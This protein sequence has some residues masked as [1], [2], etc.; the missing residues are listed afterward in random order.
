MHRD[1]WEAGHRVFGLYHFR[2]DKC[3]CG[4]SDC[5]AAGKHPVS[6]GWQHTPQWD[7]E[8]IEAMEMAG[9]F[10]TGFGVL[11]RGL[12]VVDVD[13][14]N[15]GVD[16]YERLRNDF[17]VV[18]K[19]GLIVATG[20]GG[21][22]RHVYF[23][24]PLDLALVQ[25]HA[26]YP[27]IDFKSSGFVVGPGSL[28]VSGARYT[29]EYGSPDDIDNAPVELIDLL[30]KPDRHRSEVG[31]QVVDV[32]HADLAEM[33]AHVEA[34]ADHETWVRCGMAVHHAS[35]GTGFEIW[36]QWSARG[37]KYPGTDVLA[38]RWHSFGKASNPVTLGTLT[39]YAEQGGWRASVT[40]DTV[41]AAPPIALDTEVNLKRPPGLVGKIAEWIEDQCR[42]PREHLAVAGA[43]MAVG[44]IV[45]LRYTDDI[46]KVT[47]NLFTF[48]VAAS[49]TGKE[50]VQQAIIECHV[51]AGVDKA[52]HGAIK[53]EQEIV[54]NLV[55]HQAS[56]YVV[57]EIGIFLKKVKNA[58]TKGGAAYLDGIIGQL[59]SAYSKA[60]GRMLLTGD[61][62]EEVRKQ[63]RQELA[64]LEKQAEE[65][66]QVEAQIASV[67]QQMQR[68]SQGLEKPFL[69]L[70]G[71]TTPETFD[72]LVDFHNATNGFIGRSVLFNE[73]E[74]VPV[75][76][77]RFQ[78]RP[79]PDGIRFALAGLYGLMGD[80]VEN[81]DERVKIPTTP[82][83]A[84]MLDQVSRAF[85]ELA[86]E[87]KAKTGLEALALRAYEQVAKVSL[88]LAVPGGLRTEEHVR[89]AYA[90]IRRD[91]REKMDL[92]TS[93]DRAK[94]SPALALRAKIANQ[95][96][97]DD[98][99]TLGVI[100]N[101]LRKFKK[102]DVERC[103]ADMVK[104]GSATVLSSVHKY[105]KA[106]VKRYKST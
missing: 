61:M 32:S 92:V 86:E 56:L 57:D 6:S 12:L 96:A 51:A 11:I 90:L 44:N 48:C 78:R 28:H 54:R 104:D 14:R 97:N 2:G 68:L 101:R 13:A 94:D 24:V 55:R 98:G 47:T 19:A 23:S 88:I 70:A 16:S 93:N 22:S 18:E 30:R 34:D 77:Y 38:K 72:E 65:G 69:S 26:D 46:D 53:S 73:R 5:K 106:V 7:A 10:D 1:F 59:M 43:L 41:E 52:T 49:G 8:Q 105:N 102:A 33:L 9:Q 91:V 36:N 74:T 62:R 83:A 40:F 42:R 100:A 76:K 85:D 89:W 80:R 66:E 81:Y 15:G 25:K 63:M 64:N 67:R 20:S 29:V 37:S 87:Q 58:Q 95:I 99:E 21:G 79:M 31:G 27:G 39:H 50:A 103:L 82:E 3:G 75:K 17:P 84:D 60:D 45:G 71:F 35:A 4:H